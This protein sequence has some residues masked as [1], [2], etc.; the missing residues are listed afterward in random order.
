MKDQIV[1]GMV[2]RRD[3]R[4][5]ARSQSRDFKACGVLSK[6]ECWSRGSVKDE[7]MEAAITISWVPPRILGELEL[8]NNEEK[9]SAFSSQPRR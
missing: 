3:R 2:G 6:K 9:L 1:V 4:I 8:C 5:V 7:W